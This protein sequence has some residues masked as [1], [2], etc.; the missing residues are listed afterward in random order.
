MLAFFFIGGWGNVKKTFAG[1]VGKLRCPSCNKLTE[2]KI[3]DI[4]KR[5]TAYFIPV[6]TYASEQVVIC[7]GCG[8]GTKVTGAEIAELRKRSKTEALNLASGVGIRG[9]LEQ[10]VQGIA[11][12]GPNP[13]LDDWLGRLSATAAG[14]GYAETRRRRGGTL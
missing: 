12:R 13:Q 1:S 9:A 11:T 3:Y 10:W 6:W 5:A 4:E 7:S 8:A 2:W 14:F